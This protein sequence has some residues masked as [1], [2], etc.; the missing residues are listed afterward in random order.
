MVKCRYCNKQY[1]CNN[2]STG[3]MWRHIKKAH[4]ACVPQE[5]ADEQV[6][7]YTPCAF[8]EALVEWVVCNDQPFSEVET[9]TLRKV[10]GLLR[11]G[12]K[13]PSADTTRNDI[14]EYFDKEK[15]RVRAML[16]DAPG[17]LSFAVDAWTSTNT[18]DFLG[19]TVHW[20]DA[21]WQLR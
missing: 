16:Q 15:A 17:R 19:I 3:N 2:S 7:V 4:P 1:V 20:I 13:V 8:R 10:I 11:P 18:K 21:E 9:Q 6:P 5:P 14:D 12:A